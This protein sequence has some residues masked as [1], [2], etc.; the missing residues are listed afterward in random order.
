MAVGWLVIQATTVNSAIANRKQDTPNRTTGIHVLENA[1]LLSV[2]ASLTCS[3]QKTNNLLV[4][5]LC[6]L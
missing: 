6:F 5:F 2:A 3:H 1:V 4:C